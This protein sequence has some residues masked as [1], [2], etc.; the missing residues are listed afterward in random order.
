MKVRFLRVSHLI[1]NVLVDNWDFSMFSIRETGYLSFKG[2]PRKFLAQQESKAF[3]EE[4]LKGF[5][6]F[7]PEEGHRLPASFLF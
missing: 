5:V 4:H 2:P 6:L 7:E 3:F 1:W